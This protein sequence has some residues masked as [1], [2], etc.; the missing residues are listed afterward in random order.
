MAFHW[1][2]VCVGIH[3][4]RETVMIAKAM[5]RDRL[6]VVGAL[7][8]LWSWADGETA[9]GSL[10]GV[11]LEDIDAVVGVDGFG[12]AVEKAGWI[13]VG[14]RGVTIPNFDR[15]NGESAKRRALTKNRVEKHR[16]GGGRN[17]PVTPPALPEG[18]SCNAPSV[19]DA[20]LEKRREE[21]EKTDRPA[22][23]SGQSEEMQNTHT[24]HARGV[25]VPG[26][27][28]G[29]W[30][31][32]EW[33]AFVRVWNRTERA[34]PWTPLTPP[35]GWVDVAAS[36]GW[37]DRARAA[38]DHLPRCRWFGNPL[39]VTRFLSDGYVDRILA[40]EFDQP[41]PTQSRNGDT[42][43]PLPDPTIPPF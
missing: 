8:R 36:P 21:E 33:V 3:E 40:G 5:G 42:G 1:V 16:D 20:L 13:R 27:D 39:A 41:K 2:K 25:D 14:K 6:W 38:L 12:A 15:H 17:G 43:K 19:T 32:R 29:G 35:N 11:G 24:P 7:V 28:G 22:L 31:L 23:R 9:D 26:Q 30:A 37:L 18:G 4:K 10:D 34:V